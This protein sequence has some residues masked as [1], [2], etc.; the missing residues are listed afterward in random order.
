[1]KAIICGL[2]TFVFSFHLYAQED[3][4]K[5]TAPIV[6]E[7]KRLYRS[8]MA[9]WYGTDLFME[10]YADKDNIGGYFSYQEGDSAKCIF[11]SREDNPRVIGTINFEQTYDLAKA[12][13]NLQQRDFTKNEKELYTIR[14]LTLKLLTEDTMFKF[15][16]NA[17]TNLIPII[18][19]GE[20]KVYVLTATTQQNVVIFGNDYL[21]TFDK[22]NRLLVKKA[23]H[24]NIIVTD[25]GKK[26]KDGEEV[27]GG[28]HTHLPATGDFITA[29]D[30][31]TLMLYSKFAGWK[32]YN[33]ISANY[34][35][36]WNCET[37]ELVTLSNKVMDKIYKDQDT[38]H[39]KKD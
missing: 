25:Y 37:N 5:L 22:D 4:S 26:T 32:S 15:Y 20:K 2:F 33:I 16:K 9:S 8:E 24:Q 13:I 1:M 36:I 27:I 35:S 3:V 21:L 31:C 19:N 30:I 18:T 6:S 17:S 12:D 38:R 29:T 10:K 7:G 23:L 28:V 11:F 34:F 14:Q 39:P